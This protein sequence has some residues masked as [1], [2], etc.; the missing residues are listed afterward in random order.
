MAIRW[1]IIGASRIAANAFIP[2][3]RLTPPNEI[4]AIG[5]S[6]L[7]KAKA[8]AAEHNITATF[9]SYQEL[10][11]SNDIDAIYIAQPPIFHADLALAAV[12]AGKAVLVEKPFATTKAAVAN[13]L[14]NAPANHL[15]WEALV[16]AFHPQ[17]QIAAA[18]TAELGAI[19][20][21]YSHFVYVAEKPD[22][23]RKDPM[24]GGGA[25]Q[26][27]GT[28]SLRAAQLIM[29]QTPKLVKAEAVLN[30]YGANLEGNAF[31]EYPTGATFHM[32]WSGKKVRDKSL[33]IEYENGSVVY[34]EPFNPAVTDYVLVRQNGSTRKIPAGAKTTWQYALE[35]IAQVLAGAIAPIHQIKDFSLLHADLLEQID[36]VSRG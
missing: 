22:D 13:F 1:G 24:L 15:A 14:T 26:D 30:E 32:H 3:L 33:V 36:Q 11:D 17:T 2:N 10:I 25:L 16:F 4:V 9:G 31:F 27:V 23:F 7:A 8:Y 20:H 29:N 35:H 5:A 12:T 34:E 6:S 28:Y 19:K 18:L 21:I